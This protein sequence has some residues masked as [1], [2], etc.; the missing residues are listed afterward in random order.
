ML[1]TTGGSKPRTAKF[2]DYVL[3]SE[4]EKEHKLSKT[5]KAGD[6]LGVNVPEE[7]YTLHALV[8]NDNAKTFG[9][10]TTKFRS[11]NAYNP[12]L[13]GLIHDGFLLLHTHDTFQGLDKDGL[14]KYG[15]NQ[16]KAV[17]VPVMPLHGVLAPEPIGRTVYCL[18]KDEL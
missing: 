10:S 12:N 14:P 7:E 1:A 11:L 16:R 5:N 8:I 17:P 2:F 3:P 9:V 6:K 15:S 4:E 13:R 18:P